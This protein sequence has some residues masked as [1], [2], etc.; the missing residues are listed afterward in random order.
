MMVINAAYKVLKEPQKRAEYDRK[1][2][3]YAKADSQSSTGRVKTNKKSTFENTGRYK[4]TPSPMEE[5]GESLVDIFSDMWFDLTKNSAANLFADILAYIDFQVF[6]IEISH[7]TGDSECT[8]QL[9]VL[10][11]RMYHHSLE[12]TIC[13]KD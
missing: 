7:N 2:K 12:L 10:Q 11:P 1:R 9:D 3:I 13:M 5:A 8:K 6:L 4:S